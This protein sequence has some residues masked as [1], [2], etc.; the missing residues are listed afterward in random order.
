MLRALKIVVPTAG[1]ATRLRPQTW[2]KPKPLLGLAGKTVLDHLLETFGSVPDPEAVEYVFILG[3]YLGE[4]QIPPFMKEHYPGQTVHYVLQA[5]MRGQS[6]ALWLAREYL[7]G[8]IV[9][10]FSDTLIETDFAFLANEKADAVAWVKEVPDPRRF[11]VVEVGDSGWVTR[12]I[13]KPSSLENNQALVGCY[14]F[15]EAGELVSAIDEQMHRGASLKGEYFL[16]DAINIMIERGLKLRTQ[17]VDLWLDTGTIESALET[18]RYLLEH[19]RDNTK[20]VQC[21]DTRIVPPVFIHPSA[22]VSHS[23]IGPHVSVGPNCKIT[24]SRIEDSILEE[25]VT[26]ENVS[27]R[28]SFVGRQAQVKSGSRE[29]ASMVVNIGDNSTVSLSDVN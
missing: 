19:G 7:S 12:L 4:T 9:M 6:D 18:N 26:L 3:A 16:V 11:G 13:E 23:I 21:E 5:V 22:E 14:Y 29:S 17:G 27:L 25:W 10:C 28:N 24:G 8:P 2:S 1:W 15:K 20:S